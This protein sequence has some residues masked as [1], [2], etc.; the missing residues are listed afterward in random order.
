MLFFPIVARQT[1]CVLRTDSAKEFACKAAVSQKPKPSDSV[2]IKICQ[3]SLGKVIKG[4]RRTETDQCRS[5]SME[6]VR[7]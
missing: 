2:V 3:G 1:L 5:V 7:E 6:A 4:P